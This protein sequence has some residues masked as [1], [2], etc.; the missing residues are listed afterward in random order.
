MTVQPPAHAEILRQRRFDSTDLRALRTFKRSR[1]RLIL[2][3]NAS[4]L[5][6]L[7]APDDDR[8]LC[9]CS[10]YDDEAQL[11]CAFDRVALALAR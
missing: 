11:F 6:H 4:R 8:P 9:R 2:E 7:M 5:A 1:M 10:E 3:V